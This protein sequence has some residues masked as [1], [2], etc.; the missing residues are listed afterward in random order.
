ML[1]FRNTN[2]LDPEV[3]NRGQKSWLARKELKTLVEVHGLF[4]YIR[5]HVEAICWFMLELVDKEALFT[6]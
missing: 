6:M 4:S 2:G 1:F 3:I 5:Y